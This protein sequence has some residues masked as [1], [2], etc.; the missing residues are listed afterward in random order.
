MVLCNRES[1]DG[2]GVDEIGAD[3]DANPHRI[4]PLSG[5]DHGEHGDA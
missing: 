5:V 1:E 4:K 2:K 3:G